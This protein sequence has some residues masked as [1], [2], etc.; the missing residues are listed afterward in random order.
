MKPIPVNVQI[1][2]AAEPEPRPVFAP[3]ALNLPHGAVVHHQASFIAIGNSI[4]GPIDS[5]AIFLSRHA[6]A[7]GC[8]TPAIG[9][10]AYISPDEA[11]RMSEQLLDFAERREAAADAAA[12]A[13]I[14]KARSGGQA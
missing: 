12:R 13:A 4:A 11:R 14:D 7:C 9:L 10:A 6:C 5:I 8:N 1:L 2:S 3:V